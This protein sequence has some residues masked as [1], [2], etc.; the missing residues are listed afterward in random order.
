MNK[1]K[2]WR[3]WLP[4][5]RIRSIYVT[6]SLAE[7]S[8][9]LATPLFTFIFFSQTSTLFPASMSNT[10]RAMYFAMFISTFNIAKILSNPVMGSMSDILGRKKMYFITVIGMLALAVCTIASLIFH[11]LMFF[12]VG[13]FVYAFAWA[14]KAVAAASINDVSLESQKVKNLSL[15]Q[16]FIGVGV[17]IG[18]FVSGY[19]GDI[20]IFGYDYLF[21][22]IVLGV[23]SLFLLFYVKFSVPETL[24][25]QD[26]ATLKEYLAPA[27]L[28]EIFGNKVIYLLLTIHIFNQLSWGTYYDFVPVVAKTVFNYDVK[29]VGFIVGTIGVCLIIATGVFI[30]LMKKFFT[31]TQMINISCVVGTL[32]VS[33]AY[34]SSFFPNS[35]AAHIIFWCSTLPVA[36]GDVIL[37]CILVSYLSASVSKK[38]QGTIVGIVY[39]IGTGMWAVGAPIG[40]LLM[41]WH[42][43]G[44][45]LISPISMVLLVILLKNFQKKEWFKSLNN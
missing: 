42:M 4:P 33:S 13:G 9:G 39:I 29:G 44:A 43:N 35:E 22:F 3:K 31:N 41:K 5:R 10:D 30:P 40:A 14:L 23:F 27:N 8:T 16:F 12:V 20:R 45:L 24:Q 2:F 34:L 28:K 38:Y 36:S 11:S 32:G 18:P 17:S 6:V 25:Q 1:K 37:F 7:L 21:P 15:M 26:K 19:I